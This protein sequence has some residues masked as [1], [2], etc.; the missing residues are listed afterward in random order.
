[1]FGDQVT[2]LI[3]MEGC[4]PAEEA[5][6]ASGLKAFSIFDL[7]SALVLSSVKVAG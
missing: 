1:M 4:H 2:F 3:E 7:E 5:L 6:E